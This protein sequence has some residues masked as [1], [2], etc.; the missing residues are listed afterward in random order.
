MN[1][2]LADEINGQRKQGKFAWKRRKNV[3]AKKKVN[4]AKLFW[5]PIQLVIFLSV[6]VCVC[7]R[8]RTKPPYNV[9][10]TMSRWG[11]IQ[12]DLPQNQHRRAHI[13]VAK[14]EDVAI[15]LRMN[16]IE[17]PPTDRLT[18]ECRLQLA[19]S[20]FEC[21]TSAREPF[22]QRKCT[23]I[24]LVDDLIFCIQTQTHNLLNP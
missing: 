14:T 6:C 21:S 13:R 24:F 8:L 1:K 20:H 22:R 19:S 3:D 5:A 23:I 2:R 16:L 9:W 18:T 10:S 15:W 4:R 11:H 17:Q 7:A 12:L